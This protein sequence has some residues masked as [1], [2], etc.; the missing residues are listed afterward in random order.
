MAPHAR[1]TFSVAYGGGKP[2]LRG[3]GQAGVHGIGTVRFVVQASLGKHISLLGRLTVSLSGVPKPPTASAVFTVYPSLHLT[4]AAV[5]QVMNGKPT[6][7]ITVTGARPGTVR[8]T[9]QPAG[10]GEQQL[11]AAGRSDGKHPL[12]LKIMLGKVKLPIAL[13]LS[14]KVTTREGVTETRTLAIRAPA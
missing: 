2:I 8:V 10:K 4:V 3:S 9:A 1:F 12:V 11:Q 5:E 13:A 7:A 6:V 14:V